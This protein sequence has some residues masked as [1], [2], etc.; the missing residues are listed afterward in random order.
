[1]RKIQ[2][3]NVALDLGFHARVGEIRVQVHT[4]S[5]DQHVRMGGAGWVLPH[6]A[7]ER[8]VQIVFECVLLLEAAGGGPCRGEGGEEDLRRLRGR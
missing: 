5:G 3:Q 4:G 8:D 2:R 7:R 6:R 1:M